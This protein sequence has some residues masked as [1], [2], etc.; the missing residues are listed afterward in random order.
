M[1]VP[2]IA[3]APG[4]PYFYYHL[5]TVTGANFP[6]ID[7]LQCAEGRNPYLAG[8]KFTHEN[9]MDMKLYLEYADK[10][11]GQN[12]EERVAI[13]EDLK[14]EIRQFDHMGHGPLD[15]A[16]WDLAGKKLGVSVSELL[17]GYRTHWVN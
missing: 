8:I 6:M 4:L 7:F 3:A 2:H 13:Y 16:L 15:I 11:Y 1:A 5:P 14:R 10:K 12:A 9:L 17:G